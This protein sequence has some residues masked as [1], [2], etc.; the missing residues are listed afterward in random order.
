MAWYEG[1]QQG[2]RNKCYD[3]PTLERDNCLKQAEKS[4]E[5][6]QRERQEVL[7]NKN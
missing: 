2:Q 1:L 3:L 5:E 7:K 6:Y 4:Y